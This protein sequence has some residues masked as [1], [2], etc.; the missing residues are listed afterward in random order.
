MV[1]AP[2]DY[3]QNVT[4][5]MRSVPAPLHHD[6]RK[7]AVSRAASPRSIATGLHR[8]GAGKVR[9][10]LCVLCSLYPIFLFLLHP[11]SVTH[12]SPGLLGLLCTVSILIFYSDLKKQLIM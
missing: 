11:P 1:A 9:A 3:T 8:F 12:H 5:P 2:G 4:L 7:Q 10:V 6:P